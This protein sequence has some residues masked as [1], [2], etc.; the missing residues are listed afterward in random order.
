MSDFQTDS[1]AESIVEFIEGELG[2]EA[3]EA[4][5]ALVRAIGDFARNAENHEAAEGILDAA[6]NALADEEI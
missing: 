1:N 6:A 4:I 3:G 5:P 2:L